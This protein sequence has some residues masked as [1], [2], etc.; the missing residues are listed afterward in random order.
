MVGTITD[1]SQFHA[2]NILNSLNAFS[3]T[4]TATASAQ[5]ET[6]PFVTIPSFEAL[7][8]IVRFTTGAEV[9]NWHVQVETDQLEDWRQ[10][11]SDNFKIHQE[12]QRAMVLALNAS[13]VTSGEFLDG[14]I[15]PYPYIPT[16]GEDG[17][18]NPALPVFAP[19]YGEGPYFP[20][21]MVSPPPFTP[22]FINSDPFPWVFKSEIAAVT[23]KRQLLFTDYTP[24]GN[25]ASRSIKFEDH[26]AFHKTLVEYEHEEGESAFDHPHPAVMLPVFEKLNDPS[27]RLVGVFAVVLP[28]DKFLTDLLPDNVDGITCVV[29]SSCGRASTYALDGKSA[30]YMGEGDFHDPAYDDTEVVIPFGHYNDDSYEPLAGECTYR[31]HIFGTAE[32]EAIYRHELPWF[33][34]AVVAIA[35]AFVIATF[36]VY[37]IFVNERNQQ[38]VGAATKTS[39]IVTSLFPEQVRDRLMA[40]E[41]NAKSKNWKVDPHSDAKGSTVDDSPPIADLYPECTVCYADITGFTA[42]SSTRQPTEVFH[43]LETLYREFD[44]IASRRSVFK[45]ETVADSYLCCTGLPRPQKTHASI[46]VRFCAEVRKRVHAMG[47]DLDLK[48]GPGTSSLKLR[49]GIHS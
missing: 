23:E 5:N 20:A 11:T 45:V 26:E 47:P 4:I 38:A 40:N 37:D 30:F 13:T 9:I 2:S 35:F 39:A 42:W 44:K 8:S 14:D 1:A 48:L 49:L 46:M 34:T 22:S 31:Y 32:F 17:R 41:A 10:Y 36:A 24:I 27:S 12:M 3:D 15:L 28:W 18:P 43:L 29:R 21:W 6:F 19:A 16:F 25:L 7:A 33:L